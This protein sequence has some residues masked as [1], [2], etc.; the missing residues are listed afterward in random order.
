MT[1]QVGARSGILSGV[2]SRSIS[3]AWVWG[4]FGLV[5]CV[6]DTYP[7]DYALARV[8]LHLDGEE[9]D[10]PLLISAPSGAA[11]GLI[12]ARSPGV[13]PLEVPF[14]GSVSARYPDGAN[15]AYVLSITDLTDG[16]E[17]LLSAPFR[18]DERIGDADDGNA[19]AAAP[20]RR[21]LVDFGVGHLFPL[22][23]APLSVGSLP[24]RVAFI[25][26]DLPELRYALRSGADF[27]SGQLAVPPAEDF[28]HPPHSQ[29]WSIRPDPKR[30]GVVSASFIGRAGDQRFAAKEERSIDLAGEAV[31]DFPPVPFDDFAGAIMVRD[32]EQQLTLRVETGPDP[33]PIEFALDLPVIRG[34]SANT[35]QARWTLDRE[36]PY[37]SRLVV[38]PSPGLFA[39]RDRRSPV[40]GWMVWSF[41]AA[42]SWTR[43]ELPPELDQWALTEDEGLRA[44]LSYPLWAPSLVFDTRA[45][46]LEASASVE[47]RTPLTASP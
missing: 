42:T 6:A 34:F 22:G 10:V 23:P 38:G 2:R 47:W 19:I 12:T 21:V 17:V 15:A 9:G 30:P 26:L 27:V 8:T 43:P 41:T 37:P 13:H 16:A 14:G 3:G 32:G 35:Q 1:C 28:I 5:G 44:H 36:T 24:N 31:L 25:D 7:L 11:F 46:W 18:A 20:G 45:P 4:C 39:A 29:R 40:R 33:E